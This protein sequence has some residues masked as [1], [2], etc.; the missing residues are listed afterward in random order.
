MVHPRGEDKAIAVVEAYC[1]ESGIHESAPVCVVV[2]FVGSARNWQRFEERWRE[3]SGG[4]DFH[5]KDFFARRA[6]GQRVG[7]YAGWSDQKA[8]K[9]LIDL[10][11]V[12]TE[13]NFK[14]IGAVIETAVRGV[15]YSC[16]LATTISAGERSAKECRP[17]PGD[18]RLLSS[19]GRWP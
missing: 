7:P 1:D 9:Y 6:K 11:N 15:N 19:A 12:I 16:R 4:V 5:G 3:A 8:Q 10:V 13:T 18:A 17:P 14:P 2:G